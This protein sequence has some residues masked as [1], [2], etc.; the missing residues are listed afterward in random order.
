M[1]CGTARMPDP[2][3]V[4]TISA[5]APATLPLFSPRDGDAG[6]GAPGPGR[7]ADLPWPW[8]F[9]RATLGLGSSRAL[10]PMAR[11]LL[12]RAPRWPPQRLLGTRTR[13]A[14][15]P[16]VA[17]LI[18][19]HRAPRAMAPSI[20]EEFLEHRHTLTVTVRWRGFERGIQQVYS[21]GVAAAGLPESL[22]CSGC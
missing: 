20:G 21:V 19:G 15:Q 14:G 8:P 6:A 18:F 16:N 10:S 11:A 4:P 5:T 12:H 13:T 9:A 17:R 22:G 3:L 7:S 2:M 1:R